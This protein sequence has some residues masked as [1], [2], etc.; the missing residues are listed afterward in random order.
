MTRQGAWSEMGKEISDGILDQ[1]C[2][3]GNAYELC[4]QLVERWDGMADQIS[5]PADLWASH[6]GDPAWDRA[7][8][9]L[10]TA[11]SRGICPK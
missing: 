7:T 1:F 6:A 9:E 2:V 5:L 4:D 10:I 3:S 8:T 11:S